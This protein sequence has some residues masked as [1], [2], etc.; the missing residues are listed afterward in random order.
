MR[1]VRDQEH[2]ERALQQVDIEGQRHQAEIWVVVGDL[3]DGFDGQD[4][5]IGGEDE[6]I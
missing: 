5:M 4:D 2:D 3:V 1:F 6:R